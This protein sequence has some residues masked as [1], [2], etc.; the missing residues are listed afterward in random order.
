MTVNF[1]PGDLVKA[2]GRE[3]VCPSQ[4]PGMAC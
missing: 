3:W 2:R 1:T 4:R